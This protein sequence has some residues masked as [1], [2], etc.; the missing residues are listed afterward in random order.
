MAIRIVNNDAEDFTNPAATKG[1]GR[2]EVLNFIDD[3]GNTVASLT[4]DASGAITLTVNGSA[5]LLSGAATVVLDLPTSD[6]GVAGQLWS[7]TGVVTVSA[8]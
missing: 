7:D 4:S 6:P 1:P 3:K 5:V 2:D 8:G